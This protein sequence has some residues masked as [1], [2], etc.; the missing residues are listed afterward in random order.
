MHRH[1]LVFPGQGKGSLEGPPLPFYPQCASQRL[2]ANSATLCQIH[3]SGC[4]MV[5]IAMLYTGRT[6][7]CPLRLSTPEGK[8]PRKGV[9]PTG[10]RVFL[11][12][13]TRK[14]LERL[15]CKYHYSYLRYLMM[16]AA[17]TGLA[18]AQGTLGTL[19]CASLTVFASTWLS[20]HLWLTGLR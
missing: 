5:F 18:T 1:E 19:L 15:G 20:L 6:G 7:T 9:T 13:E 2:L 4:A 17:H 11:F 8:D 14:C 10:F 12:L 3:F 16:E